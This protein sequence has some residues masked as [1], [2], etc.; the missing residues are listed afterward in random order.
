MTIVFTPKEKNYR[1]IKSALGSGN[2]NY[3]SQ[4]QFKVFLGKHLHVKPTTC[5]NYMQC[6]CQCRLQQ[7]DR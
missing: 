4:R 7:T 6:H 3:Y 2:F 5:G 1:N